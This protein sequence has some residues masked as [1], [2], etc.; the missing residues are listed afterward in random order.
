M[1][2]TALISI[3]Q[4][5]CDK[6]KRVPRFRQTLHSPYVIVSHQYLSSVMFEQPSQ[7]VELF[8]AANPANIF[9]IYFIK[10]SPSAPTFKTKLKQYFLDSY[11]SISHTLV[12]S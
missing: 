5:K 8:G 7:R 12:Y 10:N 3:L 6:D 11:T 2:P 9:A 4:V 1:M